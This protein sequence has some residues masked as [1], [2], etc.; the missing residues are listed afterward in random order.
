[1]KKNNLLKVIDNQLYI[2]LRAPVQEIENT[3]PEDWTE[4]NKYYVN[5]S[6]EDEVDV[7][8]RTWKRPK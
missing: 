5:C 2:F 3:M 6:T 1:M 4:E 7:V 8:L